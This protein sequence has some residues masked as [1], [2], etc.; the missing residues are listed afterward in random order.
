VI[1]QEKNAFFVKNKFY[2]VFEK[3]GREGKNKKGSHF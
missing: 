1:C 3:Q 2:G